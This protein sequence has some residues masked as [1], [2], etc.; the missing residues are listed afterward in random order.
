MY[1]KW[2]HQKIQKS[3]SVTD[4]PQPGCPKLSSKREGRSL[5]LKSIRNCKLTAPLLKNIWKE[6]DIAMASSRTVKRRVI[7]ARLNG[8]ISRRKPL[9]LP[10]H[11]QQHLQW[12]KD[13]MDWTEDMWKKALWSDKS[14]FSLFYSDGWM[15]IQ[16]RLSEEF[17]EDCI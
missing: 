6:E 3:R 10:R 9:L 7:D 8:R 1:N 14:K 5:V 13:H 2:H 4:E 15:Y 11:K 16:R 12:A 17:N